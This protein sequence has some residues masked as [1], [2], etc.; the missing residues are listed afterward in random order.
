MV[1]N[2]TRPKTAH[3]IERKFLIKQVPPDLKDHPHKTI[4]QGY[5]AANR[6]G[7]QVRLRRAGDRFFLTYKRGTG[8]AREEREVELTRAQF[9]QLWPGTEGHRLTKTR[10]DVPLGNHI[11]EIDVYHGKNSG[12]MVA[13]VEFDDEEQCKKF[14]PPDWFGKEVSGEARYSNVKLARE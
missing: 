6:D 5:L 12:L 3:E 13:E 14:E 11:A 1:P 4:D 2:L 9:D 10:Y 7:V 8:L